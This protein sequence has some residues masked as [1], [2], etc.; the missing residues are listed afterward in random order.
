MLVRSVSYK[1]IKVS[2]LLIT[3]N[4]ANTATIVITTTATTIIITT[5]TTTSIDRVKDLFNKS[6]N[7]ALY[8]AYYDHCFLE[9]RSNPAIKAKGTRG[10]HNAYIEKACSNSR[11]KQGH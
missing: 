10:G 4:T 8:T 6:G 7:F 9:L 3:A 2:N 5:T 1:Y 11:Y